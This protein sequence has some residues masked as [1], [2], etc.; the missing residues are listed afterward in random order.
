MN[1]CG[2]F[3]PSPTGPLHFGSLVAAVSSY[4]QA[5][6]RQGQWLVRIDD[7]D[8]PREVPGS[9]DDILRTLDTLEMHW[10]DSVVYQSSRREAYLDALADLKSRGHLYPCRCS[11]ADVARANISSHY[12]P[13]YPLTCRTADLDWD[14]GYS[15]RVRTDASL[16]TVADQI[17]TPLTQ[18]LETDL[19]DYVLQRAD[20]IFAYHLATV[21]DDIA[22][23]ITDIVRGQDLLDSTPRQLWL[24]QLLDTNPPT[25]A[26]IPTAVDGN[27][28]KLS[29]HTHAP[30]IDRSNPRSSLI[31]ALSFVGHPPPEDVGAA[32]LAEIWAWAIGHWDLGKVPKK[33]HVMV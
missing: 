7:L 12:G 32:P 1:Y 17:Q 22:E 28:D 31:T 6:S 21:V 9:A 18:I 15:V 20:G 25:Y 29:K 10:D 33:P 30:P 5:R 4:L 19:G 2:R 27:G 3:A 24:Y 11:R 8:P 13:V 14:S 23:G 16:I 26:H